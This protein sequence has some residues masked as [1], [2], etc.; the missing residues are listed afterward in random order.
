[1]GRYLSGMGF[2]AVVLSMSGA[3]GKT[4]MQRPV[5]GCQSASIML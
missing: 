5:H 1:M 4:G 2:A 3:T